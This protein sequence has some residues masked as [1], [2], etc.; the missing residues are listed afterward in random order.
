MEAREARKAVKM[1]SSI[2]QFL[3]EVWPAIP[4]MVF[5]ITLIYLNSQSK[6]PSSTDDLESVSHLLVRLGREDLINKLESACQETLTDDPLFLA[7]LKTNP[8]LISA[9]EKIKPYVIRQYHDMLVKKILDEDL[10]NKLT[11]YCLKR[12]KN[13]LN[14]LKPMDYFKDNG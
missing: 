7:Q 1:I 9:G 13:A 14:P 2:L 3:L 5:I 8:H 4:A 11:P 6:K 12:V 10:S